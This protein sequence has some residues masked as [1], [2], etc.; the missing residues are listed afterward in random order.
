MYIDHA[1]SDPIRSRNVDHPLS[2]FVQ[3]NEVSMS[4]DDDS[5]WSLIMQSA[6][7]IKKIVDTI[8]SRWEAQFE[9]TLPVL[10]K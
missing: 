7:C 2:F 4:G 8:K 5:K 9:T 3:L 10:R 1:E 6:A